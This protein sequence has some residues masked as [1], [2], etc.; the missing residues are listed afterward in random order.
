MS[1]GKS[2]I[3]VKLSEKVEAMVTRCWPERLHDATVNA[4]MATVLPV[5]KAALQEL[6][7]NPPVVYH[8]GDEEFTKLLAVTVQLVE[9]LEGVEWEADC[10]S[11]GDRCPD[12]KADEES[13]LDGGPPRGTHDPGCKLAAALTRYR[14]LV[15][16]REEES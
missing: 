15:G 12:C 11:Y 13:G 3:E 4:I 5:V 14:S 2:M 10:A 9:A 1:D 6:H 8:A 16:G 7:D